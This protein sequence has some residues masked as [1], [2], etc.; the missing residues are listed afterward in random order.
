MHVLVIEIVATDRG[1]KHLKNVGVSSSHTGT[2]KNFF[3]R[4]ARIEFFWKNVGE[5]A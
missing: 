1:I 4:Y 3:S 5:N 2:L